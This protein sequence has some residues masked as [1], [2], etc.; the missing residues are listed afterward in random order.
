MPPWR[1]VATSGSQPSA[2]VRHST[3]GTAIG[4]EA[5]TKRDRAAAGRGRACPRCCTAIVRPPTA[6]R[7]EALVATSTAATAQAETAMAAMGKI[8]MLRLE[9]DKT[10]M[11]TVGMGTLATDTAERPAATAQTDTT[12]GRPE[13]T[14]L[15]KSASALPLWSVCA[16]VVAT[17]MRSKGMAAMQ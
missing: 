8:A 11:D 13:T 3:L 14:D 7:E 17:D 12:D 10:A 1:H 4:L 5:C 9:M 2:A 6:I 16:S 15:Y